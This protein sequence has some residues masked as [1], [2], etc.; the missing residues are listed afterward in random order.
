LTSGTTTTSATRGGS[1]TLTSGINGGGGV[2]AHVEVLHLLQ[3]EDLI[4][5]LVVI[6]LFLLVT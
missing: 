1:I 3:V 4:I 5:K 2:G 6:L